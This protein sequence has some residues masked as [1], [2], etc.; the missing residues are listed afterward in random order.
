MVFGI[1]I[2]GDGIEEKYKGA[3]ESC[4]YLEAIDQCGRISS[5]LANLNHITPKPQRT[6][7]L[8]ALTGPLETPSHRVSNQSPL[9]SF[10]QDDKNPSPERPQPAR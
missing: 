7:H 4:H 8:N 3:I 5:E 1:D 2:C 6:T 10:K 9:I